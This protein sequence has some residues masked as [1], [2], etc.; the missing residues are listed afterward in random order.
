[1][2][3]ISRRM[4]LAGSAAIVLG[5]CSST[6]SDGAATT[7]PVATEPPG[8]GDAD[9]TSS[10]AA[11]TA[12]TSTAAPTTEPADTAVTS[13]QTPSPPGLTTDPFTLGVAS[14]DP[15]TTSVILWTRLAPDPLQGGGMPDED[16]L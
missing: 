10:T 11:T 1:M 6:S 5:A 2:A 14:G 3:P 8:S 13:P 4:F 16:V 9:T 12:P 7:Q 15:D